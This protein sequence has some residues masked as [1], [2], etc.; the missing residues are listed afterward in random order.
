MCASWRSYKKSW[1]RIMAVFDPE[2]LFASNGRSSSNQRWTARARN[3]GLYFERD[4]LWFCSAEYR[5]KARVERVIVEKT[6]ELRQLSN[7]CFVL[8]GATE[9][10]EYRGFNPVHLLA[11][12]L[13]GTSCAV[14]YV[15][16]VS[17]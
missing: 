17:P 1:E 9:T 8:D 4:M 7:A 6:D 12:G 14:R 11:G 5:V 15:A 3:R 13:A 16:D 2:T 10:E